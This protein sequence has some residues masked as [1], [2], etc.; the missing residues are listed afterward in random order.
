VARRAAEIENNP[1]LATFRPDTDIFDCRCSLRGRN[2]QRKKCGQN[3]ASTTHRG[4]SVSHQGIMSGKY[5]VAA[6]K[7]K[8]FLFKIMEIS[9]LV[10]PSH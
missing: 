2:E 7:S 8:I 3:Q 4:Q 9:D 6:A 10:N 5:T 1:G